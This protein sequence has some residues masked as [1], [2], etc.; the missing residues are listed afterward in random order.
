LERKN[1]RAPW[2]WRT[3]N[4]VL[5]LLAAVSPAPQG[6]FFPKKNTWN[7]KIACLPVCSF[8]LDFST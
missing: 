4:K 3:L 7:I 2:Q 1:A 6:I 8:G 5:L